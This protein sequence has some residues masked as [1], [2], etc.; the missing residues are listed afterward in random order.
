ML[1]YIDVSMSETKSSEERKRRRPRNVADGFG[2]YKYVRAREKLEFDTSATTTTAAART[3]C[4]SVADSTTLHGV[5]HLRRTKGELLE[6][7]III[8]IVI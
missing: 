6:V 7:T 5:R 1:W 4:H 3:I 8:I 2:I